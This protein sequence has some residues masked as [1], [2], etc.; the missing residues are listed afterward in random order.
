MADVATTPATDGIQKTRP[1]KPDEAKF[2]ADLAKAEKDHEAAQ[3]RFN[4]SRTKLDSARPGKST[5]ANDRFKELVDEQKSIRQKQQEHKAA[6][7]GQQD[8][9]NQ[10]DALIKKLIAEQKDGR[11]RAGFK[12][13]EEIDVKIASILKQVDSGNMKLVDEKKAL[14]EVSSLRRQKKSF[15]GLD[16]L[17][18]K[19]DEKKAENAELKKSFDNP[20][21]RALSQK[22]EDNQKELDEIKAAREDTNKNYDA[23]KAEREKLYQEQQATYAAIKRV[24]DEYYAQKKAYKEYEDQLYQQRRERQKAEREAYEKEK[25]RRIAEQKLEEASEPAFLDQIRTAEGLIRHFDPS[26][27]TED[28]EKGPG[29]FAATAQRTIDESGFKGMKVMKKADEDFFVGGGGKKKGK[30][31]KG[32]AA[33]AESGKLNMNIGV[34][35][36]LAKVGVD[37]PSTQADVPGVVEKLKA[38][39]ETWKRDQGNQTQKNIEKAK[40]EIEKLEHE[41]AESSNASPPPKA[42]P[43]GGRFDRAKKTALK[44]SGVNG[45]VSAEGEEAQEKDAVADAAKELKEAK[46]EDKENEEVATP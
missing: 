6:K 42:G 7:A 15:T 18:K 44:D 34:I 41:A 9:Y 24:K 35:E 13:V 43:K 26:Y 22:Y 20:E 8:K 40:K 39:L 32:A 45:G 31:K 11:S 5:P 28:S 10:N 2:K 29:Q 37:P 19:I 30:G 16:D 38:K 14:A 1:E 4:A 3:A 17:Q 46:I 27:G 12:N 33:P 25:R 23:L 36:E 21:T